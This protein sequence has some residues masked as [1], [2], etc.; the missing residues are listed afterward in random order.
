MAESS[1]RQEAE[2]LDEGQRRTFLSLF[3][4]HPYRVDLVRNMIIA[5]VA[6]I[7]ATVALIFLRMQ[8]IDVLLNASDAIGVGGHI[9]IYDA[10]TDITTITLLAL[11]LFVIAACMIGMLFA[12]RV[13]GPMVGLVEYI[14]ELR[15][16]NYTYERTL[17]D[18][19]T[20]QPVQEALAALARDLA[21]R[22]AEAGPRE[23]IQEEC[24]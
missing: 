15:R 6:V 19:D 7:A 17:R 5:G 22:E 24:E 1:L 16:G 23:D 3:T 11:C 13:T 18:K 14:D 21:K 2:D 10:F 9:P 4:P 12:R 8:D 20:L